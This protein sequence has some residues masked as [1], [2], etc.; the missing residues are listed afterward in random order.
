MMAVI[1]GS[2]WIAC[3]RFDFED[4]SFRDRV[5]FDGSYDDPFVVA[6]TLTRSACIELLF[7]RS[8]QSDM[9]ML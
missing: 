2:D 5:L 8:S 4:R 7:Y 1:G 9:L 3:W 6:A